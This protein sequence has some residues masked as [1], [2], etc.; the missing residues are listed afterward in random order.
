MVKQSETVEFY[1]EYNQKKSGIV[2]KLKG[3]KAD[4]RVQRKLYLS[5]PN[6]KSKST[7]PRF[8]SIVKKTKS[9]PKDSQSKLTPDKKPNKIKNI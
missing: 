5:V 8:I 7:K 3:L 9:I 6:T 2:E 4:I 1:D